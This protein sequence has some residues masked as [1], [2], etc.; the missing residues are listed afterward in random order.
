MTDHQP[1]IYSAAHHGLRVDSVTDVPELLGAAYGSDGLLL[2]ETDLGPAFFR[3]GSGVA[4]E[5]FQ[6]LVN[7]RVPTALVV[8]DFSA[9]GERFSELASEH[10]RHGQVRFVHTEAE[11]R[12]W[13][14]TVAGR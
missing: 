6:K 7:H 9:Y 5:L 10:T 2:L 13:L 8:E 4:G 1:D 14:E 11:A 3:L 12:A